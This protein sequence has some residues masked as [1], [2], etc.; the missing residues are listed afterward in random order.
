MSIKNKTINSLKYLDWV[1]I[2]YNDAKCTTFDF[3]K[4]NLE[5]LGHLP[6]TLEY[7]SYTQTFPPQALKSYGF[8]LTY[9]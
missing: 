1:T 8:H 5:A 9:M 7:P 2:S 6:Y 3:S 4:I